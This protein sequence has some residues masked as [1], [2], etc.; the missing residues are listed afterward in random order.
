MMVRTAILAVLVALVA[1][2]ARASEDPT[3]SLPGVK[4]LSEW[5]YATPRDGSTP[6]FYIH[7]H[8]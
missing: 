5:D 6:L 3:E 1:T 2:G 4:D 7:E 8:P